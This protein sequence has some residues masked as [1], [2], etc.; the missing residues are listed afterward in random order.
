MPQDM[1]RPRLF[2]PAAQ[3][4]PRARL[5]RWEGGLVE[6]AALHAAGEERW[7]LDLGARRLEREG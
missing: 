7:A 2:I 6:I 4:E 3:R 1:P 5:L